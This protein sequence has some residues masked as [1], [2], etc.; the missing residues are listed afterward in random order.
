MI[1]TATPPRLLAGPALVGAE[2]LED[3]L[4]RLGPRPRGGRDLIRELELSGLT[5]R[6]GAA[7]PVWRKWKAVADRARGRAVVVVNASEGEPASRKDQTLWAH[8]PHLV[9]DGAQLAAE[10]IGAREVIVYI[11]RDFTEQIAALE[12]ALAERRRRR[13]DTVDVEVVTCPHRY[14]AGESSAV[15]NHI[16]NGIAK[17]VSVPPRP[18]ER[19][20]HGR[21]TLVQNSETLAPV[22][23][24]ARNGA[25]WFREVG[26]GG[27]P[28][29]ALVTL[30]GAVASPGVYEV[31][32]GTALSDVVTTAGGATEP[33]TAVLLGGYFGSWVRG[34]V[35]AT[36][37]LDPASLRPAGASL[38]C[39]LV[40]LLP[41]S[42]CGVVETARVI[43]YLAGESAGQCGPCVRGLGTLAETLIRIAGGDGTHAD[44]AMLRHWAGE[45]RGRG[46]CAHPDGAVHHLESAIDVFSGDLEG[47]V[48]GV[49]C[50]GRLRGVPILPIPPRSTEWR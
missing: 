38:G 24:I 30:L 17:P 21:P 27:A 43:S 9:L 48:S 2:R 18:S 14:V 25:A 49:R 42:R 23:L 32:L 36:L 7:Y 46:E 26:A 20:V 1:V 22:A 16:N 47:H 41:D 29:T 37:T 13:C 5:G 19:G 3:H 39:G 6:G 4:L 12:H 45:I 34:D 28:G 33:V 8:R 11:A 10:S 31:P 15:V 35:A 44:I 50:P 40:A